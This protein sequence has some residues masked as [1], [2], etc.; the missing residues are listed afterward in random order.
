MWLFYE[1][2]WLLYKSI[3]IWIYKLELN[4]VAE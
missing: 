4:Q 2:G 3:S 1:G